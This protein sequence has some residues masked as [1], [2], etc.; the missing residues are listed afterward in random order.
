MVECAFGILKSRWRILDK[1]LDSHIKF[2]V[3]IA[4]GCIVH[5]NFCIQARDNWDDPE[6]P[7]EDDLNEWNNETVANGKDIMEILK[8]CIARAVL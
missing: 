5:Q 8:R 6:I 7:P 3:R 2:A 1:R 4:I